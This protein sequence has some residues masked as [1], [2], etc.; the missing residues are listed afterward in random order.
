M[1]KLFEKNGI[2][3]MLDDDYDILHGFGF[4][5]IVRDID[6]ILEGKN[7]DTVSDTYHYEMINHGTI[8]ASTLKDI[9]R[10]I[11][12]QYSVSE[13]E[14]LK[15]FYESHIGECFSDDETGLYGQSALYIF[16]LYKEEKQLSET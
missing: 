16:S 4:E 6:N 15:R 1:Y 2:L 13:D 3:E 10:L 11:C 7:N 5:Y 9:I 8:R 14:A 12:E